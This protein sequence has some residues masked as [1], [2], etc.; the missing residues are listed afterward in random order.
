MMI[1]LEIGGIIIYLYLS[2]R[3]LRENYKEE[4]VVALSWVSLLLFM[5]G[6]RI[7]YGLMHLN[8]WVDSPWKWFEFWRMN[9]MVVWAAYLVW[10]LF[11]ALI[12]RDKGWKLWSFLE[13]SL[14]SVS[15][16]VASLGIIQKD[17][18]LIISLAVATVASL[19]MKRRYRSIVWYKSGK[20]G[21]L[22]FWFGIFFC[23]VAGISYRVWWLS[24]FS[25]IFMVGLY[26]LGNDKFSK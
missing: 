11:T 17:W 21:F 5:F 22:Y 2:W 13:D 7:A 10:L 12:I 19:I 24:G 4:D 16:L 6:G 9:E 3:I 18:P 20:K 26:M 1:A 23:L 15:I 8:Q 25:L 14:E